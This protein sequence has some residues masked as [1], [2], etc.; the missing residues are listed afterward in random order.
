MSRSYKK[1][2]GFYD[3]NPFMKSK[4]NEKVRHYKDL[5]DGNSYKKVSDSWSIHD[6]KFHIWCRSDLIGW[7]NRF[8]QQFKKWPCFKELC[9]TKTYRNAMSK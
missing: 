8:G 9:K 2:P 5:P 1:N 7:Q 4:A 3:R 6:H